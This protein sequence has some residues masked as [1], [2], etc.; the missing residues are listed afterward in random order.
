VDTQAVDGFT[1]YAMKKAVNATR[2]ISGYKM[3]N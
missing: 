2:G 3:I 1:S